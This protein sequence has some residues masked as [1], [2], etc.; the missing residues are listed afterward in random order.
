MQG[1]IGENRNLEENLFNRRLGEEITDKPVLLFEMN[2]RVNLRIDVLHRKKDKRSPTA[3]S[4]QARKSNGE[5]RG[6]EAKERMMRGRI[7][8]RGPLG[9]ENELICAAL[10]R[11]IKPRGRRSDSP[12]NTY[13]IENEPHFEGQTSRTIREGENRKERKGERAEKI[14]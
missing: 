10:R 6:L 11:G 9:R 12:A 7:R 1:E 3:E 13:K 4:F 5:G 14:S 8:K 2:S